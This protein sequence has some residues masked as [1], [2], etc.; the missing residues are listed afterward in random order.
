MLRGLGIGD[1]AASALGIPCRPLPELLA[2][3]GG[4]KELYGSR[5]GNTAAALPSVG[6]TIYLGLERDG[7]SLK[8][9]VAGMIKRGLNV[10]GDLVFWCNITEV[11]DSSTCSLQLT[12]IGYAE[13]DLSCPP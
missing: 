1:V 7:L 6:K 3:S 8:T 11:L 10:K 2:A 9:L 5:L 13:C 4:F 12:V